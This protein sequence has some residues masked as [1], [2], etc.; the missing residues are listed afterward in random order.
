MKDILFAF[1][2][3]NFARTSF[4]II[5]P[6]FLNLHFLPYLCVGYCIL[7]GHPRNSAHQIRGP[8]FW[9]SHK[10]A[11][12]Y[13]TGEN[14]SGKQKRSFIWAGYH[15][16][17]WGPFFPSSVIRAL[18]FTAKFYFLRQILLPSS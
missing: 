9:M 10:E 16:F 7:L 12:P 15:I 11:G 4:S 3:K 5:P 1:I 17:T 13:S 2:Q 8:L 18:H 14:K 6:T